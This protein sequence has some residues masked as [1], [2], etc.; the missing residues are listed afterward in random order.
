ME[1]YR[2]GPAA[3]RLSGGRGIA[4]R[5]PAMGAGLGLSTGDVPFPV[6]VIPTRNAFRVVPA[7]TSVVFSTQRITTNLRMLSLLGRSPVRNCGGAVPRRDGSV[8]RQARDRD[9][10]PGAARAGPWSAAAF[11]MAACAVRPGG[12]WTATL[13]MPPSWLRPSS[14][15]ARTA[16]YACQQLWHH[17]AAVRREWEQGG[18]RGPGTDAPGNNIA[19][20]YSSS[21]HPGCHRGL[22]AWSPDEAVIY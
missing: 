4:I 22:D 16:R 14:A 1:R 19:H 11:A 7:K 6:M 20:R 15:R 12:S 8:R 2:E 9:V 3:A 13:H 21:R 18:I 10:R 5:A 17:S